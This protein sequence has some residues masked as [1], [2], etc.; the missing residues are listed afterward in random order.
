MSSI[1][2]KNWIFLCHSM[3]SYTHG[4][5]P[6][7]CLPVLLSGLI[8]YHP[9]LLK[10]WLYSWEKDLI[11]N[12]ISSM[13]HR[14]WPYSISS[15]TRKKWPHP[16]SSYVILC[17]SLLTENCLFLCHT[18][19]SHNILFKE[20]AHPIS[21]FF[22]LFPSSRKGS[23]LILSHL[24]SSITHRKLYFRSHPMSHSPLTW[25]NPYVIRE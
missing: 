7:L 23:V 16:G 5:W 20:V 10:I 3:T 14:K 21:F 13:T 25:R 17:R 8:L 19:S 22:I 12:T 18:I 15:Y 4:K 6:I 1:T 11:L 24:M 9:L 2:Y